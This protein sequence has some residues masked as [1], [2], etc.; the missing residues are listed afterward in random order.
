MEQPNLPTITP[1]PSS[2]GRNKII[3]GV[4][5]VLVVGTYFLMKPSADST[6]KEA[7]TKGA[8]FHRDEPT[9]D[10]IF[11]SDYKEKINEML[12]SGK[13]VMEISKETGVRIDEVRK[14][15]K[16]GK[17]EKESSTK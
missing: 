5:A 14:I 1:K 16:K 15:K 2:S 3:A 8:K 13:S 12:D 17:I 6:T 9:K 10:Q 11:Q 4:A 7:A